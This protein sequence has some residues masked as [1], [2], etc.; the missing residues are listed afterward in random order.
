[1]DDPINDPIDDGAHS[2]PVGPRK[3]MKGKLTFYVIARY[4]DRQAIAFGMG[5][6]DS[7]NVQWN[8]NKT[9][10]QAYCDVMQYEPE[11]RPGDSLFTIGIPDCMQWSGQSEERWVKR[12]MELPP[13]QRPTHGPY[14]FLRNYKIEPQRQNPLPESD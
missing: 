10:K 4:D 8:M 14:A 13:E 5:T 9:C 6:P 3:P 2:G 7:G 12:W 1:M 11:P